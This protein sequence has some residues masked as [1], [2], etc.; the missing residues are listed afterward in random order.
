LEDA[1]KLVIQM[2]MK[3]EME[4]QLEPQLER[5]SLACSLDGEFGWPDRLSKFLIKQSVAVLHEDGQDSQSC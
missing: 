2:R 1:M 3:M 5:D 4:P